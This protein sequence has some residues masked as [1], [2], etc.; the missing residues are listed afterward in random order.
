MQYL[1]QFNFVVF[2]WLFFFATHSLLA[3]DSFKK[4]LVHLMGKYYRLFYNI[5][6]ILFFSYAYIK[7]MS[8]PQTL[9]VFYPAWANYLN[10]A[11]KASALGLFIYSSKYY[12]MAEFLG[13]E[14]IL[15][16]KET[17]HHDKLATS[18]LHKIVRHPWYLFALLFI[19]PGTDNDVSLGLN[20]LFTT[21]FVIGSKLEEKKLIKQFGDEYI[22][23]QKEVSGIIPIKYIIKRF[24]HR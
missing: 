21:Y 9:F 7:T 10:L 4:V 2:L 15:T 17:A 22:N 11:I 19:W 3:A 20:I 5:F 13:I 14:Q 1:N 6:A 23:Y 12:N 24:F 16:H 8:L 18:P